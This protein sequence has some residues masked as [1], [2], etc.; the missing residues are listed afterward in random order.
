VTID[1]K[2]NG[3]PS[4]PTEK[5]T[6]KVIKR[7][8]ETAQ[9]CARHEEVLIGRH[10]LSIASHLENFNIELKPLVGL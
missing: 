5:D 9:F 7:L 3:S 2:L 4:R 6:Q 8:R 10:L 1:I